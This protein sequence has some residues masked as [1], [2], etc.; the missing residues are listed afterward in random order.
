MHSHVCECVCVYNFCSLYMHTISM[1]QVCRKSVFHKSFRQKGISGGLSPILGR[2]CQ[3]RLSRIV[4]RPVLNISTA[5]ESTICLGNPLQCLTTL[6][7]KKCFLVII[8]CVLLIAHCLLSCQWALWRRVLLNLLYKGN[9][10][11]HISQLAQSSWV[12]S[13]R[14]FLY[15]YI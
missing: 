5:G 13:V 11:Q 14:H 3:S 1:F 15:K 9:I 7:V 6:T 2:I 10:P 8:S 12:Q 4:F